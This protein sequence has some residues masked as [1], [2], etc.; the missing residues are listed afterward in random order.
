MSRVYPQKILRIPEAVDWVNENELFVS[1]ERPMKIRGIEYQMY[2][3]YLTDRTIRYQLP[4]SKAWEMLKNHTVTFFDIVMW[5]F[6]YDIL[7]VL[8]M[9]TQHHMITEGKFCIVKRPLTRKV[10]SR[11]FSTDSGS[12]TIKVV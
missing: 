10:F 5:D 2:F 12:S 7:S 9:F 4:F 1:S 8:F 6:Q 11:M 3:L